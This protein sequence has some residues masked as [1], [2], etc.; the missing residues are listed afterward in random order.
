MPKFVVGCAQCLP[1]VV[2]LIIYQ[3]GNTVLH[4]LCDCAP[5]ADWTDDVI[6]CV[7]ADL[8][9]WLLDTQS[10]LNINSQNRVRKP[11]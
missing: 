4:L 10:S 8:L 2:V 11:S 7:D 3:H 9:T 5:E 1:M 6:K